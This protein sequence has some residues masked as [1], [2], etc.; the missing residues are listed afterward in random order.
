MPKMPRKKKTAQKPARR[1]KGK[2]SRFSEPSRQE[3]VA[4]NQQAQWETYWELQ[5]QA[6]KAWAKLCADV[7]RKAP[8]EVIMKDRNHLALLL[9]ECNYMT[10]ECMNFEA[11]SK[12]R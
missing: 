1:S 8:L 3:A 7:K 10:H 5:K 6:D 12:K 2:P 9:G 11:S 4:C